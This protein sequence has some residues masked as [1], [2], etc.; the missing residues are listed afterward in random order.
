MSISAI[1]AP[2]QEIRVA[3]FVFNTGIGD[4]RV[5]RQASRLAL[6]G[7]KV[8]IYC[9]LEPGMAVHEV[10]QATPAAL[11]PAGQP[12][13]YELLRFDQ[14]S[15]FNRFFD[16]RVMAR[17]KRKK[18]TAE[19]PIQRVEVPVFHDRPADLPVPP[20]PARSLPSS[21]SADERRYLDYIRTI[22]RVW[23]QQ[24]SAWNPHVCQAHD[25]DALEAAVWTAQCCGSK[26]IY[27]SHE[28]WSDQPFIRTQEQVDYWNQLE[29]RNIVKADACLSVSR[30]F[31]KVIGERYGVEV[32]PLHNCQEFQSFE[33]EMRNQ[34]QRE[35]GRPVALYQGVYGPDRGLEE[36]VV[37]SSYQDSVLIALRGYGQVEGTLRELAKDRPNVVLLEK[38]HS[39]QIVQKACEG[40]IGVIPFQPTCLNHYYNT[41]NKMFEFMMAGLPIASADLPDLHDFIITNQIGSLFDPRSL[42]DMA[43]GIQELAH[44]PELE[45]MSQRAS[46]AART[47]WNWQEEGK[48]LLSIYSRLLDR[49]LEAAKASQ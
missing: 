10:R 15:P 26:L 20:P 48:V 27:D 7:L 35:F 34:L 23:F 14:R 49:Q 8:R 11:S 4:L 13:S 2:D 16:D 43:R 31:S 39:S 24:A 17:L 36:L 18:L 29:A 33:P 40:T 25:L 44:H 12:I 42:S 38:C 45:A 3:F 21:A 28:L 46:Q 9:F 22:N 47:R 5:H 41:P 19:Q 6:A 1:S 30:P 32:T 37:S